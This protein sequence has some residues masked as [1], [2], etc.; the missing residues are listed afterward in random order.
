MLRL[1]HSLFFT[2]T[3]IVYEGDHRREVLRDAEVEPLLEHG[4]TETHDAIEVDVR[5]LS[6][7][8]GDDM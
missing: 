4:E 7:S 5:E 3:P 2:C 8:N 6:V 1:Q